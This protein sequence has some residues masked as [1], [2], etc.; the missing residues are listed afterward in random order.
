MNSVAPSLISLLS[1]SHFRSA[2]LENLLA[3]AGA[4]WDSNLHVSKATSTVSDFKCPAEEGHFPDP[5]V[6]GVYCQ[7]AGGT[8]N[9]QTCQPGLKWNVLIN[10]CDW[11]DNVDCDFNRCEINLQ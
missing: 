8:A 1:L 9:A 10:I 4:D 11:E 3:I 5:E 7:C 6:C 2:A